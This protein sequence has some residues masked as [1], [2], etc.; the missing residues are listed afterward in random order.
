MDDSV[1]SDNFSVRGYFPLIRKY[2]VTHIRSLVFCVMERLPF[3][4]ELSLENLSGFL[5]IF[6]SGFTTF[7]VLLLFPLSITFSVFVHGFDFISSKIDE[8]L[9]I[10]P[11]ANVFV[12][13]NFNVHNTCW[14]TYAGRTERHSELCYKQP[15]NLNDLIEIANFPTWIPVCNSYSPAFLDLFIFSDARICSAADFLLLENYDHVVVSVSIEFPSNSKGDAPFHRRA[16]DYYRAD[17]D[18]LCLCWY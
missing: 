13:G 10:N 18:G 1:D 4:Q 8:I 11:S 15:S 2:S 12:S 16:Y 3:T 6:S 7:S 17:S 9:S 14:L 5:F